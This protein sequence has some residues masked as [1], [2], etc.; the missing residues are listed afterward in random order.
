MNG[1]NVIGSLVLG[2]PAIFLGGGRYL[3]LHRFTGGW[4][5]SYGPDG[6]RHSYRNSNQG[7]PGEILTY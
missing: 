2:L 1:I 3:P 6:F 5:Q 7:E 4:D